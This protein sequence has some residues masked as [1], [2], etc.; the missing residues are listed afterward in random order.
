[1]PKADALT[2]IRE[3]CDIDLVEEAAWAYC[4]QFTATPALLYAALEAARVLTAPGHTDW[5]TL[6]AKE[7]PTDETNPRA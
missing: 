2:P 1:M 4:E 3:A 6:K 7:I 5:Y